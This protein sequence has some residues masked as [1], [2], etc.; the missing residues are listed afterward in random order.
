MNLFLLFFAS[1]LPNIANASFDSFLKN[2]NSSIVNPLIRLLF[3]VG[4][5]YFL[6]GAFLFLKNADNETVRTEGKNHMLYGLIGLTVM[7]GVWGILNFVLNTLDIKGINPEKGTVDLGNYNP[8]SPLNGGNT[9][10]GSGNTGTGNGNG[11]GN[12]ATD[13]DP[14]LDDPILDPGFDP[15]GVDDNSDPVGPSGF[16]PVINVP[17]SGGSNNGSSNGSPNTSTPTGFDP[18]G[19]STT[20]EPSLPSNPTSSTTNTSQTQTFSGDALTE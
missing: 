19:P 5:A 18:V 6:Y 8:S 11:N 9:N 13:F 15:V 1:F 3:A 17:N 14:V 10:T 20:N 12:T 2:V 7:M 16:D 4:I